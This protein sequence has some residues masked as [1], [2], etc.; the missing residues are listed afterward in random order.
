MKKTILVLGKNGQLSKAIQN[1]IKS[2]KFEFVFIGRQELNLEF[3]IYKKLKSI[4]LELRPDFIINTAAYTAVDK[5]ENEIELA[6]KIN[7]HS[8]GVIARICAEFSIPLM[9]YSTDYVFGDNGDQFLTPEFTKNPLGIYGK[10]KLLGE[11]LIQKYVEKFFLRTIILRISWLFSEYENNFLSTI[12]K[13]SKSRDEL[14]II[15]DQWGGP[16]S[17]DSVAIASLKIIEKYFSSSE[18]NFPWG[19]YH[20]QGRPISTWFEF[21][22][23]I[24]SEAKKLDILNKKPILKTISSENFNSKTKRPLNSRLCTKKFENNFGL[25]LPN[26]QND[27]I[28]C[29]K[30]MKKLNS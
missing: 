15:N 7:G 17:A 3:D 2:S 9:H 20:F 21:A 22:N 11:N 4:V 1:F 27:L 18:L 25:N 14:D 12:I 16:T 5:A 28:T 19:E 13:L 29:L 26:W 24:I 10:S 30:N 6:F 8:V 23:L